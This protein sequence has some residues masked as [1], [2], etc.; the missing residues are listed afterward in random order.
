MFQP[1]SPSDSTSSSP[2]P[3]STSGKLAVGLT[4]LDCICAGRHP[5]ASPST[6][7]LPTR[8]RPCRGLDRRLQRCRDRPPSS[9][10]PVASKS[11]RRR[12]AH[13]PRT[14]PCLVV[15]S[16]S[17][18]VDPDV[19]SLL[20]QL[21]NGPPRIPATGLLA[22]G[23]EDND[24]RAVDPA[25][26]GG[27]LL[28][29]SGDWVFTPSTDSIAAMRSTA[30]SSN[31]ARS[32]ARSVSQDSGSSPKTRSASGILKGASLDEV[33]QPAWQCR[34]AARRRVFGACFPS[35]RG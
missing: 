23:D 20:D 8:R 3:T 21:A 29:G 19:D 27:D 7:P 18:D 13:I 16:E 32:I 25:E 30:D 26:I 1:L 6:T 10:A 9:S 22:V 14:A 17:D 34:S 35:C 5:H 4:H 15:D 24:L 2:S 12:C 33:R 28:E 31:G 11:G